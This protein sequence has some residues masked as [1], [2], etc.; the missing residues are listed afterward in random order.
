MASA[1]KIYINI[2]ELPY[3]ARGAEGKHPPYTSA[4]L[5][6]NLDLGTGRLSHKKNFTRKN[7]TYIN[8]Q[9]YFYTIVYSIS[10]K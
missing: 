6:Y 8:R 4:A 2:E 5:Y 10:I 7:G 3:V 1:I 9:V